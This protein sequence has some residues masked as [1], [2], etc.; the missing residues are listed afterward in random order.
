MIR[1]HYSAFDAFFA[2]AAVN[3]TPERIT[4]IMRALKKSF[5]RM[6]IEGGTLSLDWFKTPTNRETIFKSLSLE[7]TDVKKGIM[8]AYD[9]VSKARVNHDAFRPQV[10]VDVAL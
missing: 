10:V 2:A 8:D 4:Q 5:G 3:Q 9:V 1:T 6:N 7:M